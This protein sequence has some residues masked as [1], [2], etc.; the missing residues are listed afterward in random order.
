V[1]TELKRRDIDVN[2]TS[3]I[4]KSTLKQLIAESIA[5]SNYVDRCKPYQ[6]L[7]TCGHVETRMMREATA[8]IPWRP[9]V[10]LTA[11]A[12]CA[13]CDPSKRGGG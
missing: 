5:A 4:V 8:G 2:E 3:K 12:A 1:K 9:D 7:M 10:V 11:R 13:Q 6:V